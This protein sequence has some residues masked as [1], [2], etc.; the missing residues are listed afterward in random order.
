M[1]CSAFST[2][3]TESSPNTYIAGNVTESTDACAGLGGGVA[4]R[5]QPISHSVPEISNERKPRVRR[6]IVPP[7]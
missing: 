7:L 3:R 4:F 1:I 5:S 2:G 6:L